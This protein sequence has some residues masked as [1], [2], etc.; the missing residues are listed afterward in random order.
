M[1]S[2]IAN[3]VTLKYVKTSYGYW[4]HRVP[5]IDCKHS[6]RDLREITASADKNYATIASK[7]SQLIQLENCC[8]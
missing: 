6:I 8:T 7:A 1:M 4:V 2:H 3:H 5:M